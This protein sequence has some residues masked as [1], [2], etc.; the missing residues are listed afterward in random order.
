M[1]KKFK[2]K[3]QFSDTSAYWIYDSAKEAG[4]AV[5]KRHPNAFWLLDP[6]RTLVWLNEAD[7]INDDGSKAVAEIKRINYE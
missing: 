7:S 5:T 3:V 1:T 2:Y 6:E 4:A